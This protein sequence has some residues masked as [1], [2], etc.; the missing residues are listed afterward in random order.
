MPAL[1]RIAV[2][3]GAERL[4]NARVRVRPLAADELTAVQQIENAAGR[5]FAEIGMDEI[6]N[7]APPD[8]DRLSVY[9]TDGR[10]WVLVDDLDA[11]I[12][13]VLVDLVDGGAHIEQVSIHPDYAR[14]G[15]GRS[16]IDHVAA[17]ARGRRL[18]AVTLTTFA[19]VAW[20][21]PY[22]Q[23]LGFVAVAPGDLGPQ[24]RAI[25][26][27]EA[28]AGLDRWPRVAMRRLL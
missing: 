6:A 11:P 2:V 1:S 7:D 8:R 27:H 22:Y 10:A 20:N 3:T 25:R 16:L 18:C 9:Q 13:F 21:G 4:D 24:L 5:P 15:L 17:W 12:G 23:R 19:D 14:R 26:E 28:A